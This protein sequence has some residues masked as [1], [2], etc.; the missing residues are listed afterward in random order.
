SIVQDLARRHDIDEVYLMGFS[1]GAIL[2]YLTGIKHHR[3]FRGIIC[4]SGP[5]LLAPLVNPFAG[6]FNPAWLAEEFIQD[7]GELRVFMTHGKDDQVPYELG[8]RSRDI[9]LKHG[10]DVTFRDFD[11]GHT[12]PPEEIL[13]QIVKWIKNPHQAT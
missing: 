3:V 1:Q 6:P 10:Y 9:L 11:G 5:G 13:A 2:A 12:L 7:A 4:L 8:T